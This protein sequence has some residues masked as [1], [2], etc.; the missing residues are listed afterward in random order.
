M[1]K[2]V[3]AV[4]FDFDGTL[5]KGNTDFWREL[6]IGLGYD[7]S[8][9]SY[10]DQLYQDYMY[11]KIDYDEWCVLTGDAYKE[12]GLTYQG[13]QKLIGKMV[14]LDGAEKLFKVL[15][16]NKVSL[17]IVSG[18]LVSAIRLRLGESEKYFDN[19]VGNEMIFDK[20]GRFERI[21]P[22]KFD[23][24]GKATFVAKLCKEKNISPSDVV[25]VG[26]GD[27]DQWVYKSGCKTICIN[28]TNADENNPIKWTKVYKRLDN[29]MSLLPEFTIEK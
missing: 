1:K 13:M 15:N 27:N 9:G 20:D 26:N 24:E 4:V 5:T 19:I 11:N 7:V 10:Y 18:N 14:L 23:H 22:T 16:D 2:Y 21:I 25:F 8:E 29:L 6:W 12:K 3:K 28:P 17:N